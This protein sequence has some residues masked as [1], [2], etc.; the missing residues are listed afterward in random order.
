MIIACKN[1]QADTGFDITHEL[2]RFYTG[3]D[4][5]HV[6]IILEAPYNFAVAARTQ[7]DALTALPLRD[8]MPTYPRGWEWYKV[9]TSVS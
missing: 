1:R 3:S 5:M 4:Y 6:E 8:A 2:I 7:F 9:V